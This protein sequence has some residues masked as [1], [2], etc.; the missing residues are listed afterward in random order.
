MREGEGQEGSGGWE[1]Q[2]RE[3]AEKTRVC[4]GRAGTVWLSCREE[5]ESV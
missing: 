1:A 2:Q 4:L 3:D 5:G